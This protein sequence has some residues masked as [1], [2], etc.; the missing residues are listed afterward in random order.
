[1]KGSLLKVFYLFLVLVFISS[2]KEEKPKTGL[3]LGI[4]R[5]E[6]TA[7]NNQI[8]FNFEIYK[9]NDSI[10]INL[11]NGDEKLPIDEVYL[12]KDTISFNMFIFDSEI[13]G[14]IDSTCTSMNGFYTRKYA[15]D[16]SLPFKALYNKPGRVD[17]A[18]SDGGFDGK[19]ETV[20]KDSK[21]KESKAIGIFHTKDQI[22]KGTFLTPTGDYRY[23]DGYTDKDT[24]F[25][26]S[27]DGNQ[28][29]K[30]KAHKLND[31]VMKGEFWSG[32]AG[33]KTFISKRNDTARLP[34]ADKI[35]FLKEGY[36]KIDFS[37]KNLDGK[38][39]SLNNKK[40]KGKVVVLQIF[41]TWC[42]NCMDE[43]RFLAGWYKK[44]RHR[45]VE[46]I[47][48][49]YENKEDFEYAKSRVEKM[50]KKLNI[51]YDFVIAGTSQIESV[52]QS[53]PMLDNVISF[54]TS[55]FID[56]TGKVRKILAGFNGPATGKYYQEF[57]EDF[58]RYINVLLKE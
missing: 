30:F 20:F 31:S 14:K 44:N 23:L 46:I 3:K 50:V 26:Y 25:L 5:G 8:P 36:D 22:L 53:L 13:N 37:F 1:M 12:I 15:E 7:Q 2:C 57:T 6:I 32:K 11:I 9:K 21:G 33:Y 45:G 58:N 28:I 4:W 43:T 41:G 17:N 49:A 56:K 54:P 42:P 51:D 47:G 27:F 39:V 19:W 16:Y 40:Y 35:T 10:H 24:M 18:S 34:D 48:L 52:S 38:P 29:F 55:I